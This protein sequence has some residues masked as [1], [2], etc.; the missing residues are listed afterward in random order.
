M[1]GLDKLESCWRVWQLDRKNEWYFIEFIEYEFGKNGVAHLHH[2][3]GQDNF[4]TQELLLS[5]EFADSTK[6]SYY[7]P[8]LKIFEKQN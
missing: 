6:D 4:T 5:L 7:S 1:A 2:L 3:T 8:S